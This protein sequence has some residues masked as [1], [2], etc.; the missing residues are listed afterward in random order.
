MCRLFLFRSFLPFFREVRGGTARTGFYGRTAGRAHIWEISVLNF[1]HIFCPAGV[2]VLGFFFDPVF[3]AG[4]AYRCASTRAVARDCSAEIV[5][6]S[7]TGWP[8]VSSERIG[9][10]S[11]FL[12]SMPPCFSFVT[13]LGDTWKCNAENFTKLCELLFEIV[14]R[15]SMYEK[16]RVFFAFF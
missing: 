13:A 10:S 7:S 11:F 12:E 6:S 15:M 8:V 16:V 14:M 5:T 2:Q 9:Y 1:Y 4:I 3:Y